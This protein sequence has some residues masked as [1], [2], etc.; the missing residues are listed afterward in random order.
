[1]VDFILPV[2]KPA[3]RLC[4]PIPPSIKNVY[5]LLVYFKQNLSHYLKVFSGSEVTSA[6]ERHHNTIYG[7]SC[8]KISN[9][10]DGRKSPISS[11]DIQLH[12]FSFYYNNNTQPRSAN[13]TFESS[14]GQG[15]AGI[16]ITL[17]N[18]DGRPVFEL[19]MS[20]KYVMNDTDMAAILDYISEEEV[21]ITSE[22]DVIITSDLKKDESTNYEY[23]LH[24][25]LWNQG[26]LNYKKLFERIRTSF[27]QC[28]CDYF[29]EIS[30]TQGLGRILD[31]VEYN[32]PQS[33]ENYYTLDRECSPQYIDTH[34][35]KVFIEPCMALLKK[36]VNLENPA[37]HSLQV[38][39]DMPSW[40]MDDFLAE[41][42]ELLSDIHVVFTP[43]ILRAIP[44]PTPSIINN[45]NIYEIY[46]P[47]HSVSATEQAMTVRPQYLLIAGLK[48]L[49]K[50]YGVYRSSQEDRR[51][52]LGSD[53]THSRRS[54]VEDLSNEKSNMP[55]SRKSSLMTQQTRLLDI[56]MY[57]IPHYDVQSNPQALILYRS[58]FLA[59]S[60]DGFDLTIYT[61]NWHKHYTDLV[62]SAMKKISDWHNQ[63]IGLLN[64]ILYQKMGLF[65]H[66]CISLK[67][68]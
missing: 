66:G 23:S 21:I 49:N 8:N 15:I 14:V 41:V 51:S 42:R 3:K 30:I 32:I 6:I 35:Q 59:M 25:D 13:P 47:N 33:S 61:Y 2:M 56:M 58:C 40:M 64:S 1:D 29:I 22:E 46:R 4:L 20:D 52:S 43:V 36:S 26:Q 45:D 44:S 39:L 11:Y 28:L 65:Y 67:P 55:H 54:S 27:K 10:D 53:S 48:E 17:I 5:T 18:R 24:I 37:L 9:I 7:V 68:S 60:I 16:C 63:R 31:Q 57:T 50:K 19:P 34:V 62:F 12:E 38:R